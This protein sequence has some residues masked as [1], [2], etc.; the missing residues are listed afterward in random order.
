MVK[1]VSASDHRLQAP[2]SDLSYASMEGVALEAE[3]L[4]S[5]PK[6]SLLK[7]LSWLLPASLT[8]FLIVFAFVGNAFLAVEIASVEMVAI[9]ALFY[10][11]ERFWTRYAYGLVPQRAPQAND[12]GL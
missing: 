4:R 3:I 12:P 11:H 1:K 7:A 5:T 8:S 2:L 10:F 9:F 6:R